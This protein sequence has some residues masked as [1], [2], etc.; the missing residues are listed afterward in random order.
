M[1]AIATPDVHVCPLREEEKDSFILMA[2]D[3]VWK[4]FG[5][6]AAAAFVTEELA[7][8]VSLDDDGTRSRFD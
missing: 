8:Q 2:C 3:G 7:K 6:D 1:G 4:I 5:V